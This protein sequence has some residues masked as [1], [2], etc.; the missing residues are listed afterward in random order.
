M[1]QEYMKIERL[2]HPNIIKMSE[3]LNYDE[4]CILF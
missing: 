2:Q 1:E 4:I 3:K